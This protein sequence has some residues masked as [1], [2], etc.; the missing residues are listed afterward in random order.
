MKNIW[1][2]LLA[3]VHALL[4]GADS[5]G[6]DMA[7]ASR[8]EAEQGSLAETDSLNVEKWMPYNHG[9]EFD[10]VLQD[11]Y[12]QNTETAAVCFAAVNA[13]ASLS[14]LVPVQMA[15]A[16]ISRLK[17]DR[18]RIFAMLNG[19]NSGIYVQVNRPGCFGSM[20][21]VAAQKLG[22][23]ESQLQHPL[24]L[25]SPSGRAVETWDQCKFR[26][27]YRVSCF[28]TAACLQIK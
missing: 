14:E 1:I 15:I 20:A 4:S 2:L 27:F 7:K 9:L 11:R 19:K 3:Y 12:A 28:L 22:V 10:D 26:S 23:T 17:N 24:R 18:S 8:L 13:A 16:D 21:F 5:L 6:E 25:F